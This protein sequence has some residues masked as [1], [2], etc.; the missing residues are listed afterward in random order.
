MV[1][2]P[3]PSLPLME[4]DKGIPCPPSFSSSW[5]KGLVH[6]I[7]ASIADKSLVGLPLHGMDPPI[8][9]NQ[10]VDDTLMLSSP[11]IR[12]AL[13]ILCILQTFCSLRNGH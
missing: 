7:K 1:F 11:T 4:Y 8:S 3:T 12:E 13:Q 9:H 10:F 6:F 5:K 2:L